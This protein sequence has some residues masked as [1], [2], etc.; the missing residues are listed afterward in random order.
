MV[1]VNALFFDLGGVLLRTEDRTPRQQL[2]SRLGMTYGQLSELVFNSETARLATIGKIGAE[3]HWEQVRQTLGLAP[4]E[5]LAVRKDFWEG[6]RLD[7]HLIQYL[8]RIRSTRK[9]ALLSNAW[10]DLR[11]YI[12]TQ[13]KFADAFD[14]MI[15]SAEIGL[16][17]PDPRIYQY[18]AARF[19]I[20]PDECVLVDDFIENVDGSRSIGMQAIHFKSSSAALEELEALLNG[21]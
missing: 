21:E 10:N 8:R 20:Q 18:A 7:T 3:E 19:G 4:D 14:E 12:E 16:A 1:K 17:K 11:D 15:I 6:D 9:T 2:A 5:F 13:W